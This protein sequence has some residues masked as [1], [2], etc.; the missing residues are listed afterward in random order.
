MTRQM[1]VTWHDTNLTLSWRN[2]A[3]TVRANQNGLFTFHKTFDLD[4]IKYRNP[5]CDTNHE[6]QFR[7][8]SLQN[9]IRCESRRHI[10][11]ASS[12]ARS[13]L[14]FAYCVKHWQFDLLSV[15]QCNFYLGAS[16]TWRG[17]T[18]HLC[19]VIK[20]TFGM[21]QRRFSRNPL[22]NHLCMLIDQ[23]THD[24]HIP[25][26]LF[27][28]SECKQAIEQVQRFFGHHRPWNRLP[29]YSNRIP[30]KSVCRA[31]HLSLQDGQQA[32][33]SA[34]TVWQPPRRRSQ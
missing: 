25:Y 20:C 14:G 8:H 19:T 33:E 27:G 16:L 31:Q 1:N 22:C 11:D 23:N 24:L 5:L 34:P 28:I 12:C 6:V 10:N 13:F 7:I 32:D 26:R 17:A 21:E 15:F 2:N 4:H 29:Q 9:G 30:L 3:R 18:Y